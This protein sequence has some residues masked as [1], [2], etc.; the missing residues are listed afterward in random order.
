MDC[1]TS[2]ALGGLKAV[3]C[4]P[5]PSR[6]REREGETLGVGRHSP[7]DMKLG[8]ELHLRKIGEIGEG[9]RLRNDGN[10]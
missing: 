4:K 10:M 5:R 2:E 7:F 1:K 3:C 8:E 6:E 9:F